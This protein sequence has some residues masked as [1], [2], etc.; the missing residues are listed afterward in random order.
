MNAVTAERLQWTLT[1]WLSK[2][3]ALPIN[4]VER[5]TASGNSYFR[6][7]RLW[8]TTPLIWAANKFGGANFITLPDRKW[9]DFEAE[10][11]RRFYGLVVIAKGSELWLP[12]RPGLPLADLL[13]S[14][15]SSL[16]NLKPVAAALRTLHRHHQK[17]VR[18]PYESKRITAPV[19]AGCVS[20]SA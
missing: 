9:L 13:T 5:V 1:G 14:N 19:V 8:Y 2:P 16:P 17:S 11:Y 12:A 10:C 6:K 18:L 20:D 7:R 4:A 3:L 15:P